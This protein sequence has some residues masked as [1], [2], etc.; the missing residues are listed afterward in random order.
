MISKFNYSNGNRIQP[1][2][3]SACLSSRYFSRRVSC[4]AISVHQVDLHAEED[5]FLF[6]LEVSCLDFCLEFFFCIKG[7]HFKYVQI[8]RVFFSQNKH[9]NHKRCQTGTT[10]SPLT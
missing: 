7:N 3:K 9:S 2:S 8:T 1:W 10:S 6:C 5:H 4:W